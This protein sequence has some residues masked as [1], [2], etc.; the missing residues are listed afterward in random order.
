VF[1]LATEI[2]EG[3][4]RRA[5]LLSIEE[6]RAIANLAAGAGVILHLAIELVAASDSG[7]DQRLVGAHLEAL[8]NATRA[9]T[10]KGN[11]Q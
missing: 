1:L 9:L 6:T 3:S 11:Q 7:A 4:S 8:C 2:A 10:T 5:T